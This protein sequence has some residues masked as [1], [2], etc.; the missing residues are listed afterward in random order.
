[1]SGCQG[2]TGFIDMSVCRD[3]SFDEPIRR[4]SGTLTNP[5]ICGVNEKK[6]REKPPQER[7]FNGYK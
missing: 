6:R 3:L 2:G 7:H 4:P 1:M 5:E